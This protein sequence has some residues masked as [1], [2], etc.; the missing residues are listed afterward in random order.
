M[1]IKA[2]DKMEQEHLEKELTKV[3]NEYF[4]KFLDATGVEINHIRLASIGDRLV[5]EVV[6]HQ[7]DEEVEIST[8]DT[9]DYLESARIFKSETEKIQSSIGETINNIFDRYVTSTGIRVDNVDVNK[10]DGVWKTE[11]HQYAY[12]EQ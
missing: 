11:M 8:T 5:W 6:E 7:S 12:F 1:A 4:D 10:I 9:T 3:L 2:V